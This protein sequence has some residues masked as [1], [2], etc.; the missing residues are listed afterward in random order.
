[1]T[2]LFDLTK[3]ARMPKMTPYE[4]LTLKW[5]QL[6]RQEILNKTLFYS[7]KANLAV[8]MLLITNRRNSIFVPVM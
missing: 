4:F 3:M 1:M 7:G 5:S 6:N 2:H 8:I